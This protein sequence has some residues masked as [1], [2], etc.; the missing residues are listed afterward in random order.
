[1]GE[2]N[3]PHPHG[4]ALES[5]TLILRRIGPAKRKLDPPDRVPA[6]PLFSSPQFKEF[7]TVLLGEELSAESAIDTQIFEVLPRITEK[8]RQSQ[9]HAVD[10]QI[11]ASVAT[12]QVQLED[13]LN[14]RRPVYLS[15][16]PFSSDIPAVI[17]ASPDVAST[18]S[19]IVASATTTA[20]NPPAAS[21]IPRPRGR[22]RR[23]TNPSLAEPQVPATT[24]TAPSFA[25]T[26]PD[27]AP[28]VPSNNDYTYRMSPQVKTIPDL[29]QEWTIGFG[30]GPSVESLNTRFG[31][32]WRKSVAHR[33][34]Y[35]RRR[36]LIRVIQDRISA[37]GAPV[38]V[39][40]ELEQARLRMGK[41]LNAFIR[42]VTTPEGSR[43]TQ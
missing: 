29:W 8:L 9:N 18:S 39:I 22:P 21:T 14:G 13:L 7:A 5:K 27:I 26:S 41:G 17:T 4:I 3:Y 16:K 15:T 28:P 6:P 10:Q 35:S 11:P 43:G 34:W 24:L 2:N 38:A 20:A 32:K 33:Q 30:G 36:R 1:M 19:T 37:G 40:E 23:N 25:E 12:M 42:H 31:C